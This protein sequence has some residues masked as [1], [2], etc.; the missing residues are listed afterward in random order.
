MLKVVIGS[1]DESR[2][3][4]ETVEAEKRDNYNYD[5]TD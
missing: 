3:T 5:T 1:A 4:S 2:Q